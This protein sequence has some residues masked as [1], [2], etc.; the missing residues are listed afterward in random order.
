[1]NHFQVKRFEQQLIRQ[2]KEN[3]KS[4][5]E[6]LQSQTE[7]S[8]G[9]SGS[10]SSSG[11]IDTIFVPAFLLHITEFAF[12]LQSGKTDL[13]WPI[14]LHM[15]GTNFGWNW[16]VYMSMTQSVALINL[17]LEVDFSKV[18]SAILT[19]AKLLDWKFCLKIEPQITIVWQIERSKITKCQL[20]I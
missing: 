7:T 4:Q 19:F 1:M 9:N 10:E 5:S 12:A 3:L 15:S 18:G 16:L 2:Q 17:P 13:E 20:L 11:K 8:S 6:K 14:S